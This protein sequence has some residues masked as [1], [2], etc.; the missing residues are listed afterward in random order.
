LK[1]PWERFG[2]KLGVGFCLAGLVL[3][4]LG[5]NGAA[6]VDRIQS[7]FPYLISGGIAGLCLVVI[8]AALIIAEVARD[9]RAGLRAQIEELRAA[10]ERG[11]VGASAGDGSAPGR[12][13]RGQ[14]VAGETT[15]H[16]ST[17]RL[18]EGRG[19]LPFVTREDIANRG[20]VAC[21]V[22]EP[23]LSSG[24]KQTTARR[25]ARAYRRLAD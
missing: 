7:Q 16:L 5:W 23:S 19:D 6:S 9:D 18:L 12:S 21:R 13:G 11:A 1:I 4:F 25:G 10:L 14:F 22:C 2:A 20:L 15:F 8:G 17:C 3:V 24:R